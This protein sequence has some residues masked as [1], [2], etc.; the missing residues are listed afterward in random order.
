MK[1]KREKFLELVAKEKTTTSKKNKERIANR[2]M[3]RAS[4][5]IA[6]QVLERL[7]ELGWSQKK[8]AKVMD[9][10]PPYINKLVRGKENFTLAT[11]VKLQ[12][13]LN[14]PILASFYDD[15]NKRVVEFEEIETVVS[16]QTLITRTYQSNVRIEHKNKTPQKRSNHY[17]PAC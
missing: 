2:A 12:E 8:L 4:R 13:V 3:L 7:E 10:S 1:T 15:K 11:L 17:T 14:I 16:T 9:V 5:E 6:F